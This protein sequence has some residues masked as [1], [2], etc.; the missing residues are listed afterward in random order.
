MSPR[1]CCWA[2]KYF[3]DILNRMLMIKEEAGTTS[4]TS[5]VKSGLMVSII[6][7][8]PITVA[9]PEITSVKTVLM[10]CTTESTSLVTRERMSPTV[11]FS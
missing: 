2:R 11:F 8:T 10:F 4:T 9:M 6:T 5:R 3:W 1:I 7:I